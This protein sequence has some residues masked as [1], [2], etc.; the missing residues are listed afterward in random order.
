MKK[1][2]LLLLLIS[3]RAFALRDAADVVMGGQPGDC[4]CPAPTHTPSPS[5]TPTASPTASPS[6]SPTPTPSPSATPPVSIENLPALGFPAVWEKP[7][8]LLITLSGQATQFDVDKDTVK[9]EGKSRLRM[10]AA[11]LRKYPDNELTVEGHTDNHGSRAR[12]VSLS[13]RRAKRIEKLLRDMGIPGERLQGATGWAYDKPVAENETEAG[14]AQNRRVELRLKFYTYKITADGAIPALTPGLR[15]TATETQTP[16]LTATSTP[17][18]VLTT[19]PTET[20]TQVPT[21]PSPPS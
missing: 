21:I 10:L 17:T 3:G 12:N 8:V 2:L 13:S 6:P 15:L 7:D 9:P 1:T 18:T 11:I 20:P 19:S 14:R 4:D 16:A 5:V